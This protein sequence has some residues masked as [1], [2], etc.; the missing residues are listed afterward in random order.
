M[1]KVIVSLCTLMFIMCL[2][3]SFKCG[4]TCINPERNYNVALYING[5]EITN[6]N[7]IFHYRNNHSSYVELPF[8]IVLKNLGFNIEWNNKNIAHIS[9]NDVEYVLNIQDIT[10]F[11]KN[12]NF[13]LISPVPGGE[14]KYK[15][16]DKEL[17][18]D[19]I[20]I[21]CALSFMGK[22]VNIDFNKSMIN[23]TNAN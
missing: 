16:L 5:K 18:L 8:I 1:K 4:L 14:R 12:D 15:V 20:T 23:V 2:I 22:K 17:I 9:Y 13:N 7:V 19:D 6:E 10:L 11:M 3:F 21:K